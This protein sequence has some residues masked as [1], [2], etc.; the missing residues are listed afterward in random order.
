MHLQ[1]QT[2]TMHALALP[3]T[4]LSDDGLGSSLA[5]SGLAH[6]IALV[7][8]FFGLPHLMPPLPPVP[9]PPVPFEIVTIAEI[10]NTSIKQ[11]EQ[12]KTPT[13]PPKTEV[14]PE[15]PKPEQVQMQ[16]LPPKPPEPLKAEAIKPSVKPKPPDIVK[17]QTNPLFDKLLKDV[18]HK[19][20]PKPTEDKA[21][22]KAS[23]QPASMAPSLSDRLTISENDALRRQ[24]S[25]CWNMPIGA[26]DA[27]NLIV[28]IIIDV[29][30]DR[31]AA[32]AEIVDKMRYNSDSFFRA[33]ADSARRAVLN[34]PLCTPLELPEGKYDQW[35]RITFTFDPREML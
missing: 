18:E 23:A 16:A 35:K 22:S 13:P 9:H 28:E 21:E 10:T 17:P 19:K 5:A 31:S 30:P 7:L 14:K 8:L 24:I 29:N 27:Q 26:K 6:L 20:P 4:T 32:G 34:N 12:P 15:P 11:P 25:R 2:R 1:L 3:K 33:A